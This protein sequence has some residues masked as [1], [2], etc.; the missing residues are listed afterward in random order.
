MERLANIDQ[1][2]GKLIVS[3]WSNT[4]NFWV[5]NG[6]FTILE[7]AESDDLALGQAVREAL[8][9]SESG[10]STPPRT[11]LENPIPEA[12]GLRSETAYMKG[13]RSVLVVRGTA[14]P[15]LEVI[16][17]E[18]NDRDGFIEIEEAAEQLPPD[19]PA[20]ELAA[21]VRRAFSRCA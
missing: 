7:D 14:A 18:N 16:P 1:R 5:M 9:H 11:G 17:E 8:S 2:E 20:T 3:S 6:W 10:I 4:E 13:T 12:L 19:V 15:S 21:A